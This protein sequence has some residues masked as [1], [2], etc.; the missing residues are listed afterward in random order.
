MAAAVWRN[1]RELTIMREL[2][3]IVPITYSGQ[4]DY[5]K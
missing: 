1:G 2:A 5:S 4:D 3:N